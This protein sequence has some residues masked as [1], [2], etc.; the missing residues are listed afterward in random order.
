MVPVIRIDD[1]VWKELQKRA[2]PFVDTPNT[3]LRRMMGMNSSP[4]ENTSQE[5]VETRKEVGQRM[6][7]SIFIV[8]NAIGNVADEKNAS[9]G[10]LITQARISNK[11]DIVAS[12]RFSE[13]RKKLTT[14][15][16]IVMHQG[17]AARFQNK[18]GSGQIIAAG[19]VKAPPREL[20]EKEN[21]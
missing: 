18:Y 17:G 7:N 10:K 6:G 9:N 12:A 13:G 20:T 5:N 15:S 16:R 2:Q 8:I 11:G 4:I 3:V 21:V 14:G 19:M 1:D